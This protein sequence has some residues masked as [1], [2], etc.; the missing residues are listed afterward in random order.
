MAT[1]A[2]EE[3]V[4]GADSAGCSADGRDEAEAESDC[5]PICRFCLSDRVSPAVARAESCSLRALWATDTLFENA[6]VPTAKFVRQRFRRRQPGE[7]SECAIQHREAGML[8]TPC[9]CKGSQKYVHRACLKYWIAQRLSKGASFEAAHVCPVCQETYTLP[10]ALPPSLRLLHQ[11]GQWYFSSCFM[12]G[13]VRGIGATAST[14]LQLAA[15]PIWI[16]PGLPLHV[17]VQVLNSKPHALQKL[18]LACAT[19]PFMPI[20][21]KLALQSGMVMMLKGWC[22]GGLTGS[23]LG[24]KMLLKTLVRIV[25][26][27]E[28]IHTNHTS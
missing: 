4:T 12:L 27:K 23:L 11:S 21:T 22:I 16:F 9:L 6:V 20:Y 2:A 18:A 19:A 5:K 14:A 25:R 13:G 7:E 26:G 8:L 24:G 15:S 1:E 3:R 10:A 28:G 17:L